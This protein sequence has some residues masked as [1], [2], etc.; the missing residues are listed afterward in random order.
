[1]EWGGDIGCVREAA[2]EWGGNNVQER[3]IESDQECVRE[4]AMEWSGEATCRRER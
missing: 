1:M 3:V 2:M 4:A